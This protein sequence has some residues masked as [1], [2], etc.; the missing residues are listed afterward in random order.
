MI[1]N[2]NTVL[3]RE[4]NLTKLQHDCTSINIFAPATKPWGCWAPR[5]YRVSNCLFLTRNESHTRQSHIRF[6]T[7]YCSM[8]NTMCKNFIL[9]YLIHK[10]FMFSM[11]NWYLF[12]YGYL[13]L[14]VSLATAL[15][16][17]PCLFTEV[18]LREASKRI[19]A[20]LWLNLVQ[21]KIA[22]KAA[23]CKEVLLFALKVYSTIFYFEFLASKK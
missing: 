6:I 2:I 21:T 3:S 17:L 16:L 1:S 13:H 20:G 11:R 14:F 7:F 10:T 12:N 4:E 9:S 23:I 18:N 19:S 5:F 22:L 8:V 15:V